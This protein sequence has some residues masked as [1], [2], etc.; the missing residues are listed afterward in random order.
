MKKV[1]A[2]NGDYLVYLLRAP[3]NGRVR[4]EVFLRWVWAQGRSPDIPGDSKNTSGLVGIPLKRGMAP[5]G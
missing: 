1:T 2:A 5:W 3:P 4:Y